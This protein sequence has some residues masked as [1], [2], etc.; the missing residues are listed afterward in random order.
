M[1]YN[2]IMDSPYSNAYV[3]AEI[4]NVPPRFPAVYVIQTDSFEP[5]NARSSSRQELFNHITFD[6]EVY[7][8]K[9]SGKKSEAKAIMKIIDDVMRLDGFR[10]TDL[11]FVDLT[12]T[13]NNTVVA[14]LLSRYTA[15]VDSTGRIYSA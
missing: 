9:A 11:N 10:R 14:R 8:N 7:S 12:E 5:R 15:E 4:A 1:V 2:A 13:T 6:I 3:D